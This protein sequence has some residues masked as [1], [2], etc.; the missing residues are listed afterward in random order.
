MENKIK[1]GCIFINVSDK[2]VAI[3][4]REKQNDYSFPKGRLEENEPIKE[5]AIRETEE[6]TKR[7]CILIEDEPIFIEKYISPNNENVSLYYFLAK[8]GGESNNNSEDTHPTIWLPFDE[9][10]DILSNDSL[11]DVWINVKDKV[12]KYLL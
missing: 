3:V 4:H 10:Y 1:A 7:K 8:D 2:T 11:K 9:V 6:E 12:K 5:C